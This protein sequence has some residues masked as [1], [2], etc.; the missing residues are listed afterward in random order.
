ML[1]PHVERLRLRI[2]SMTSR[3]R[4]SNTMAI[5]RLSERWSGPIV[6]RGI[7]QPSWA[8]RSQFHWKST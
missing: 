4:T 2:I 1:R 7:D 8:L 6:G 5:V 3:T